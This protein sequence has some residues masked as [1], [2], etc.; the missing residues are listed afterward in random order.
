MHVPRQRCVRTASPAFV[1]PAPTPVRY[2]LPDPINASPAA[3]SFTNLKT[4]PTKAKNSLASQLPP[5]SP[6]R[7]SRRHA[8]RPEARWVSAAFALVLGGP[9]RD[10]VSG[11]GEHAPADTQH[12]RPLLAKP[13]HCDARA[14]SSQ[15][16]RF[17]LTRQTSGEQLVAAL[18]PGAVGENAHRGP[19]WRLPRPRGRSTRPSRVHDAPLS[20][21]PDREPAG[22]AALVA[23][24]C[25][26]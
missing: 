4:G 15:E 13:W 5:W 23:Y 12:D 22:L 24:W 1:A 9:T 2:A 8:A 17:R 26:A 7:L 16:N 14:T 6:L 10:T 21:R 18:Q 25:Q 19:G 3:C 11:G 20:A